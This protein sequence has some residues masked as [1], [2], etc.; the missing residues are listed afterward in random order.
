[1]GQLDAGRRGD[2]VIVDPVA[3]LRREQGE[4]RPKTLASSLDQMRRRPR[5]ERVLVVDNRSHELVHSRQPGL[6]PRGQLRRG[7]GQRQR[8]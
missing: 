8:W 3:D 4:H 1:M 2:D 6:Q 5:D 7:A